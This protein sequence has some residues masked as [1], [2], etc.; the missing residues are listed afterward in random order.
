MWRFGPPRRSGR[1]VFFAAAVLS[2]LAPAIWNGFPLVF[3]DT[4]GYLER[5]FDGTLEIGRSALYGLFLAAGIPYQFWPNIAVQALLTLWVLQ[6]LTRVYGLD[7]NPVFFGAAVVSLSVLTSLPWYVGQ[8]MPD[9]FLPIAVIATYLLA[10]HGAELATWEKAALA[11][12]VAVSIAFHMAVLAL[13]I[14]ISCC[15]WL[16]AVFPARLQLPVARLRWVLAALAGG[17]LFAPSSNLVLTGQFAFTP[18]GTTFLFGRLVQ[19]G[20]VSRYL[21]EHCRQETLRLCAY[22][23]E[24]PNTADGWIW[25]YNSPL[26]KLG[27]W[28]SYETESNHII[29]KTV[30]EY[31]GEH[32]RTA[33]VA[34][35]EQFATFRTGEGMHSRDNWHVESVLAAL[36]PAV[37]ENFRNSRQQRDQLGFVILNAV[38]V[39]LAWIS[40]AL[41][42]AAL[43]WRTPR[44]EGHAARGA[45][46]LAACSRSLAMRPSAA[47]SPIPTTAIKAAWSGLRRSP[48]S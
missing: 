16:L 45:F 25:D 22:R 39:P 6:L 47:S 36:A 19:D 20:I 1:A 17:L 10:F 41:V 2:L 14:A 30:Q 26:H 29:A 33:A 40:I 7:H 48:P 5:P 4:G 46:N 34:A 13:V 35:L 28:R 31:P 42:A 12:C 9:I 23:S 3:A 27:W 37:L 15:F 24:L 11:F 44:A 43:A 8:L 38:Q 21:R 18:G 32:A